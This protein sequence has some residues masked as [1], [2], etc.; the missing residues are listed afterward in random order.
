MALEF[1]NICVEKW[2]WM[3]TIWIEYKYIINDFNDKFTILDLI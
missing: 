3:V 2:S 1:K